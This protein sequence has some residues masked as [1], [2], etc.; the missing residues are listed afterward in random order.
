MNFF[1]T[2]WSLL[3][4]GDLSWKK[5]PQEKYFTKA[6]QGQFP[7]LVSSR[8]GFFVSGELKT[9]MTV[10]SAFELEEGRRLWE[11]NLDGNLPVFSVWRD[12]RL[13][14]AQHNNVLVLE[15]NGIRIVHTGM[16]SVGASPCLADDGLCLFTVRSSGELVAWNLE[17]K[18]QWCW[19]PR[20]GYLLA[21]P[22]PQS[23]GSIVIV[24][25]ACELYQIAD[26]GKVIDRWAIGP[27]T[28]LRIDGRLNNDKLLVQI[29]TLDTR[30]TLLLIQLNSRE[31]NNLGELTVVHPHGAATTPYVVDSS[32]GNIAALDLS[33]LVSK[34]R[35]PNPLLKRFPR[36]AS[37]CVGLY[38]HI[39]TGQIVAANA[40]G[41]ELWRKKLPQ[42]CSDWSHLAFGS[43]HLILQ[44]PDGF[45][46]WSANTY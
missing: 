21:S 1:C 16:L 6:R 9:D 22:M 23:D 46:I 35:S 4:I 3:F 34:P 5:L 14:L 2:S 30:P 10:L 8:Q 44:K 17:N 36:L 29:K 28:R 15:P 39:D 38:A 33:G 20:D 40:E 11:V 24:K 37:G 42:Y 25:A 12:E 13:L 27:Q 18:E 26:S 45:T 41:Q 31:V 19:K 7:W 32:T 43:Q